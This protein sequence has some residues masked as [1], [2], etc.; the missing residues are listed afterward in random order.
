VEAGV[1]L[2]AHLPGYRMARDE[3]PSRFQIDPRIAALAG[4]R[5]VSVT[6]TLRASMNLAGEDTVR[7]RRLLTLQRRNLRLLIEN[8]VDILVGG[9]IYGQPV[10]S[11]VE[12][13]RS[14]GLWSNVELLSL[15]SRTTPR[16]IHPERRLGDFQPGAEA[17]FLVLGCDPTVDFGCVDDIRMRMKSGGPVEILAAAPHSPSGS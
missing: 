15:W 9:D 14:L 5:G 3:D 8:G 4:A 6:P 7:L 12:A 11:E 2:I 16:F 1:D 13:L 17:S 10:R